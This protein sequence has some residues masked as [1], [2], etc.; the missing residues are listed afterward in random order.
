MP[1]TPIIE[2]ALRIQG[3]LVAD[4]QTHKEMLDFAARHGIKP[5]V[6]TFPLTKGGIE[7]AFGVLEGGGMRYRGVLVAEE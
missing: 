4:R 1:Y 2:Q 6:Q 3:S 5:I 7:E